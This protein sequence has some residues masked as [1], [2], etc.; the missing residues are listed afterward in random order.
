MVCW[1]SHFDC[2][3]DAILFRKPKVLCRI[4]L[5]VGIVKCPGSNLGWTFTI[6]LPGPGSVYRFSILLQP[7]SD[8]SKYAL[9]LLR[10][11]AVRTRSNIKK[12]I[13]VLA[14]DVDKLMNDKF[15]RFER[16]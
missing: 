8:V 11:G 4:W 13:P 12:Q 14:N 6:H 3:Q 10:N 9:H 15:R 2:I 7:R 1:P 5:S 16:V